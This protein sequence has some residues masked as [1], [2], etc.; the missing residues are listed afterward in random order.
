MLGMYASEASLTWAQNL[1]SPDGMW[2]LVEIIGEGTY[3]EVY[4]GRHKDTGDIAAVKVIDAVLDKEEDIKAELS[5]LEKH[6][7]HPNIVTFY[8]SYLKRDNIVDDRIWLVMEVCIVCYASTV[9]IIVIS[10][11]SLVYTARVVF[12]PPIFVHFLAYLLFAVLLKWHCD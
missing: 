1:P 11:V 7:N 12:A 6:S 5:V 2:E 10:R 9:N 8:G 3:G 4:K